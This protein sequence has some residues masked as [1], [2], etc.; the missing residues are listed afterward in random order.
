[1]GKKHVYL[2]AIFLLTPGFLSAGDIAVFQN[3]G[4]SKD[5]RYFLFAQ[6]GI[7]DVSA[8]PYAD[9]FLVDVNKNRFVQEGVRSAEF[10]VVSDTATRGIGALF[11]LVGNAASVLSKYSIDHFRTGR[12]IYL[13]IDGKEP[14]ASLD[15][16]DFESGRRYRI[17]LNQD[18]R[19]GRE[20]VSAA[21]HI[22]VSVEDKSGSATTRTIGLPHY[23]RKG[24]G[25]YRIK[26]VLLSPDEKSIVFV[27]EKDLVNPR[28][29]S[30]RFMVE[31]ATLF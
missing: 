29:D 13:L 26:Q 9:M 15:F 6:Y 31:T 30:V 12:I 2:L 16:R 28:G 11:T 5:S 18:I 23:Y 4:F 25:S 7:D 21:F 17:S 14:K 3:L 27:V 22:V 1:M 8:S 20:S 24:I 19:A 10:P